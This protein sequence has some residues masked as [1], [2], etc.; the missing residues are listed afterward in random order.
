LVS[1][2]LE[3][4]KGPSK[5]EVITAMMRMDSGSS[6]TLNLDNSEHVTIYILE[7]DLEINQQTQANQHQ[8]IWFDSSTGAIHLKAQS[9]AVLLLMSG[10]PIDEPLVSYGPFVMNSQTEIMEAMKD[11]Q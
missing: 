9:N 4:L 5:S 11:Y 8:L 10:N 6:Y 2:E 1:G 7:G 3:G